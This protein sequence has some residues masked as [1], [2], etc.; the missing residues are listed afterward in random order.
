MWK[1]K[2]IT[3]RS[4]DQLGDKWKSEEN[5]GKGQKLKPGK[6]DKSSQQVEE[7]NVGGK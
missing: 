5:K 2:E 6:E 1:E 7:V 3:K 4:K